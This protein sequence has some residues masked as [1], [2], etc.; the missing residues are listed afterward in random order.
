M[1]I[2]KPNQPRQIRHS[3][4]PELNPAAEYFL[5]EGFGNLL[6]L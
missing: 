4:A 2:D 5:G 6:N 1:T 3:S